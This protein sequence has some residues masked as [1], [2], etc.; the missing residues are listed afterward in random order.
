MEGYDTSKDYGR[1]H[2]LLDQGHKVIC[3]LS[4][5]KEGEQVCLAQKDPQ[6][7]HFSSG[8]YIVQMYL[9]CYLRQFGLSFE[10]FCSNHFVEYLDIEGEPDPKEG[11]RY[12]CK[13]GYGDV[14]RL[15]DRYRQYHPTLV[16]MFDRMKDELARMV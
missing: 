1:L 3:S 15:L 7:Y 6:G 2:E 9:D 14:M 5:P 11:M 16:S 8:N 10:H 4:D 12:T 13:V